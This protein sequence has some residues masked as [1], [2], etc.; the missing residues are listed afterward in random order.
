MVLRVELLWYT[1][2]HD[3]VGELRKLGRHL[4]EMCPEYVR[5]SGGRG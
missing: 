1:A 2:C 3:R 5:L 4:P